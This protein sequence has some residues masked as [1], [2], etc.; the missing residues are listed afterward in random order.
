ME[1]HDAVV[2]AQLNQM[3]MLTPEAQISPLMQLH[4]RHGPAALST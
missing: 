3:L 4:P 1:A 2:V